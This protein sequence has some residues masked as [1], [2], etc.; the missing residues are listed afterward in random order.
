MSLL[1]LLDA[2]VVSGDEQKKGCNLRKTTE[3]AEWSTCDTLCGVGSQSRT[4]LRG[5]VNPPEACTAGDKQTRVCGKDQ[6]PCQ[7]GWSSWSE[8]GACDAKCSGSWRLP[9]EARGFRQKSR[10]CNPAA[11]CQGPA[12]NTKPCSTTCAQS[13]LAACPMN[14]CS[15]HGTCKRR[16]ANC[17]EGEACSVSCS[18]K[19]GYYGKGC[20]YSETA[21]SKVQKQRDKLVEIA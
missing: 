14:D 3:W 12:N 20:E 10:K 7:N 4:C 17:L 1:T 11:K 6:P 16:P 19:A 15:G 21:I 9:G 18:C 2:Y 5:V 13:P 8:W